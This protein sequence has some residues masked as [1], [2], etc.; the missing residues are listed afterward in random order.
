M[1][2]NTAPPY[3]NADRSPEE[4][5]RN[6]IEMV[7][8]CYE[9]RERDALREAARDLHDFVATSQQGYPGDA[10]TLV[11]LIQWTA[12]GIMD[13]ASASPL[14]WEGVGAATSFLESFGQ[15]V[16]RLLS[17]QLDRDEP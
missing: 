15:E 10:R 8:R 12:E 14:D 5:L 16:A 3:G 13:K 17:E 11:P 7:T 6:R 1:D 4:G 9:S 2:M